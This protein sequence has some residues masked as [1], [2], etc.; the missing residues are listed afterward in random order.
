MMSIIFLALC[1]GVV[2]AYLFKNNRDNMDNL[3][4][5]I[6]LLAVISNAITLA[7]KLNVPVA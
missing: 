3:V 4:L 6:N 7:N 2:G 1:S 5:V